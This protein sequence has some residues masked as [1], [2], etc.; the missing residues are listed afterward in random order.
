MVPASTIMIID[1]DNDICEVIGALLQ[2][3]GFLTLRACNGQEALSLLNSSVDLIILDIMMPGDSGFT[4]CEKMRRITTAPI[5]YLSAKSLTADKEMAFDSGGDDYLTKP[6]IPA[7][8]L[9]RVKAILRRYQVYRGK[10]LSSKSD[11]D[12]IRINNL[13]VHPT[14]GEVFLNGT[15]LLLRPKEYQLLAFLVRNRGTVFSV[16]NLYEQLWGESYLPS[17]NNTVMVHIRNLRQ[18]IEADPQHPKYIL[19]VWGEGYKFA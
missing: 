16:Q 5:L 14:S 10:K 1:D 9:T 15:P 3:E 4:I 2:S 17:A 12:L 13:V 6:F 18:K 7:E 11:R 19:T 8:L